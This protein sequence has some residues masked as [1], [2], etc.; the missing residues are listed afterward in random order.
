M[1]IFVSV[2]WTKALQTTRN[3]RFNTCHKL[4]AWQNHTEYTANISR[5]ITY[6]V[7]RVISIFNFSLNRLS[8]FRNACNKDELT[9]NITN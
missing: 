7:I 1:A 6:L 8:P 5:A 2:A 3:K 4:K 9:R